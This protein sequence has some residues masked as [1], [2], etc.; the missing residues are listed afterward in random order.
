[1]SDKDPERKDI[2]GIPHIKNDRGSWV[3]DYS[4]PGVAE[5][6]K[7]LADEIAAEHWSID[8]WKR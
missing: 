7:K 1:M 8:R 4:Q 6:V 2:N 3:P 5:A